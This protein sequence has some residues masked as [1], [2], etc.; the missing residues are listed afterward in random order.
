MKPKSSATSMTGLPL[1]EHLPVTTASVSPV[2]R[3]SLKMNCLYEP[4]EENDS[5]SSEETERLI[6]RKL[7]ASA[8]ESMRSRAV[9]L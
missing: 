8:R 6:S 9:M 5:G 4:R 3:W 1:M 7:S 2:R